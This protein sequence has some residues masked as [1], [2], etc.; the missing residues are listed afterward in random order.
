MIAADTM[1]QIIPNTN[2]GNSIEQCLANAVASDPSMVWNTVLLIMF[3]SDTTDAIVP[4]NRIRYCVYLPSS[5]QTATARRAAKHKDITKV[6]IEPAQK[7]V[8]A[9]MNPTTPAM[10]LELF[11]ENPVAS[12]IQP[13][14]E[15]P[16]YPAGR[17]AQYQPPEN[18]VRPDSS[19]LISI[20][21]TLPPVNQHYIML[22][23]S[24]IRRSIDTVSA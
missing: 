10:Y 1:N 9:K 19:M 3:S 24:S 23:K 11:C 4:M 16:M 20:E 12:R 2:A 14:T 5:Y 18:L 7:Q 13:M 15:L 22:V 17:I 21:L 8:T 6:I